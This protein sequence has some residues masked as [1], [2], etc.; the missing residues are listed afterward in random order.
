MVALAAMPAAAQ[1]DPLAPRPGAVARTSPLAMVTLASGDLAQ[2]RRFYAGGQRMACRD[3]RLRGGAAAAFRRHYAM[4]SRGEVAMLLCERPGLAGAVR[5][6]IVDVGP[7]APAARPDHDARIIGGLSLGFPSADNAALDAR[8][9]GL[10]FR[11]TAGLTSITLPRGDGTTYVVGE[12]HHAAP[13]GVYALGIDRGS[14]APVGPIDA[15]AGVGGPAYSGLMVGDMAAAE[16]L[17]AGVL[18][19]EKRRAVEL[20]SA[21]PEGGLGLPAGTRFDFQQWYAPGA[22]TG[23][24]ILMRLKENARPPV[25][26]PGLRGRGLA[27]WGFEAA[28]LDGLAADARRAGVR[29]LAGPARVP[30]GLGERRSLVLATGDGFPVEVIEAEAR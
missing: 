28:D 7:V 21:G 2:A 27:M 1:T 30:T 20:T 3:E 18:G 23:Y 11:S 15:A 13:D 10:G 5:L 16:R 26:P 14:M 25:A 12:V 29:V 6:R 22:T 8:M 9:R 19:L 17:F 24:V 4:A